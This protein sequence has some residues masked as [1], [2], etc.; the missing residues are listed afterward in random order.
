MQA[1]RAKADYA[2]RHGGSMPTMMELTYYVLPRFLD[3]HAGPGVLPYR[4][5]DL[6]GWPA[7][8]AT[9]PGMF[10]GQETGVKPVN[11]RTATVPMPA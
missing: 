11:L 2:I 4:D 9:V 6:A 8:N 10:G 5:P 7:R 1:G 3:A